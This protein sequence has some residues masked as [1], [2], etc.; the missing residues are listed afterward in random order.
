MRLDVCPRYY[1]GPNYLEV[2]IDLGSS[3]VAARILS[4]VRDYCSS[5]T[6]DMAITVQVHHMEVVFFFFSLLLLVA[7]ALRR[8]VIH[9]W[10]GMLGQGEGE[11]EL[12]ERV[13]CGVRFSGVDFALAIPSDGSLIASNEE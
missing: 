1:H 10:L 13:I 8:C 4:L 6:V 3:V 2:D 9:I 11:N 7:I 12:P 5:I